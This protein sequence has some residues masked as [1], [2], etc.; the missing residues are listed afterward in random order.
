MD[1]CPPEKCTACAACL[2]VCPSGAIELVE[3]SFGEPRA[4]IRTD[5]CKVCGLCQKV[6]PVNESPAFCRPKKCYAAWTTDAVRRAKCA[7]GGLATSLAE[8]T[9]TTRAGIVVGT[10][11]DEQMSPRVVFAQDISEIERLKGSKYVQSEVASDTYSSIRRLLKDGR[12]VLFT[13]TPCQVAGLKSFLDSP[14]E[15]LVTVDILCHGVSPKRYF[16]EELKTLVG[17]SE[18]QIIKDVR[19]R[20]NDDDNSRLSIWDRFLGNYNSNNFRFSIWGQSS[21]GM[22]RMI[23]RADSSRNYYLAGFFRGVSLRENCFSCEYARPERASDITLGDFINLG[24]REVF[25]YHATNVSVVLINTPQGEQFFSE[26]L[27]YD[28][29]IV[30]VE[31]SY[32]ERLSYPFSIRTP[33]QRHPLRASFRQMYLEMGYAKAIRKTLDGVLFKDR[34][35][36][37]LKHFSRLPGFALDKVKQRLFRGNSTRNSFASPQNSSG[38]KP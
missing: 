7:S 28:K 36:Q 14:F 5:R 38:L 26:V 29:S 6:C 16:M 20:G 32:E 19:F 8:H 3:N 15:N 24:Q 17:K 33:T 35:L 31:R 34:L 18:L 21:D 25:P 10:A 12:F 11:W 1:I 37:R 27:K 13:G 2:N 23:Y 4:V 30:A 9:I 22:S